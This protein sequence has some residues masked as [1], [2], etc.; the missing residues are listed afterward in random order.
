MR[1]KVTDDE[2]KFIVQKR[3]KESQRNIECG[4][5]LR[6]YISCM[7]DLVYRIYDD[8]ETYE[9]VLDE[10]HEL[11]KYTNQCLQNILTTYNSSMKHHINEG[12]IYCLK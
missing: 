5:V 4:N 12:F 9:P 8:T 3:D 6:M 11:R 1:N 7:T 2:F 10:M